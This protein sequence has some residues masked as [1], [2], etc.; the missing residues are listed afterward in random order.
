MAAVLAAGRGAVLSHATAAAAWD[1]RA[2]AG[3][4]HV[5]VTGTGGRARRPGL[6]IHRSRTLTSADV[7]TLRGIPVTEPHRTLVDL[8]R[9]VKGR[10]LEGMVNRAERLIDFERLARTAPPSLRAVLNA[11]TAA[12][13]RSELEERFLELC[14]DHGIPRTARRQRSIAIASA[15]PSSPCGGGR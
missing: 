5:T 10:P 8:A 15:T 7:T 4:I 1:M 9:T 11:Y 2:S 12:T 3:A 6:R 13:T 14:D